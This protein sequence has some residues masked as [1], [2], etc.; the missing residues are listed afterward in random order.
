[1]NYLVISDI[2]G[3]FYYVTLALE[4]FEREEF[5]KII[6]LGDQLYHGPRNPL[7]EDYSPFRV[8]ERLN[9]HAHQ[10]IAIRGNCDSEVDEMVLGYEIM[11]TM[12]EII[13]EKLHL[14][15]HHG[16]HELPSDLIEKTKKYAILS[17]HTHIPTA[18]Q[19]E[20][21]FYCNPGS[22]SL[23]KNDYPSSYGILTDKDFKVF[24]I[25]TDEQILEVSF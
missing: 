24:N 25:I 17:G 23:P 15:L 4:K 21:V 12:K 9:K 16:H 18:F 19:K 8:A 1:M 11:S 14:I 2:H 20:N 6:I 10:I 3:S 13:T 5:D 22:V 7:P